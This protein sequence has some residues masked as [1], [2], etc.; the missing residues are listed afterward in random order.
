MLNNEIARSIVYEDYWKKVENKLT[1]VENGKQVDHISDFF[2]TY[3]MC[4]QNEFVRETDTYPSFKEMLKKIND[5]D[6]ESIRNFYDDVIKYL[7]PYLCIKFMEINPKFEIFK[8]QIFTL[9][10]LQT[11][12]INTFVINIFIDF[13]DNKLT[14]DEVS[15]TLYLIE[16]FLTRRIICGFKA[17]GLNN[18]FPEL[19]KT[20]RTKQK[21]NPNKT[22]DDCL[23]AWMMEARGRTVSLPTDADITNSIKALNFYSNKDY[24]KQFILA[25]ICDQSRE[26]TLLHNIYDKQMKLTIE[27]I[28]PRTITPKWQN[29]LGSNWEIVHNKWV[30]TLANLTLTAYNS[31]YSNRSFDEK[32][33]IENGFNQSPLSLNNYI[34][35]FDVWNEEALEKRTKWLTKQITK[36][37]Q[38][39]RTSLPL[40][41]ESVDDDNIYSPYE[42]EIETYRKPESVLIDNNPF[43]IK[44][45]IELYIKVLQFIQ[46]NFPEK[47]TTLIDNKEEFKV[48]NRPLITKNKDIPN[49]VSE[50]SIGIFIEINLGVQAIMKNII[51]ICEY[52]GYDKDNCPICFTLK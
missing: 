41:I 35:T 14:Q 10:F 28:M 29:D 11:E 21:N 13:I 47:F 38:Y 7:S 22:Y 31:K 34:A 52:V 43:E 27:H 50:L 37:W 51:K 23:S 32:K 9:K 4:K 39:P 44:N 33:T 25:K 45:W 36:I 42:W 17:E 8:E 12:T 6:I 46:E 15:N 48:A 20:I 5:D 1:R 3:L 2:R 40:S 24:Q 19:H 49:S 18:R 30:H 26:S 16:T